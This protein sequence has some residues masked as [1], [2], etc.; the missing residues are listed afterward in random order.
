MKRILKTR[1]GAVAGALLCTLLWGTAFPVIKLSYSRINIQSSDVGSQILFAGQR[2]FLAGVMVFAFCLIFRRKSLKIPR[3][4]IVSVASL[5]L[6]Q[7]AAQYLFSYT[8]LALTTGTKTSVITACSA[9]FAVLLAPVF[10]KNEKL[11]VLKLIGCGVGFLGIVII[12]IS[13]LSG[14]FSLGEA[15]VLIS[16]LCSGFGS[17]LSKVSAGRCDA[18][19]A[20]AYQLLLGGGVLIV[21]GVLMGGSISYQNIQGV[22]LLFYLAFVSAAAFALW[23]VLLGLHSVGRICIFNL[24]IPIFGTVWSGILLGEGVLTVQN[25]ISLALVSGGILIVNLRIGEKK[26]GA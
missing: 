6:V 20:T 26:N 8:G 18:F 15:L 21:V 13:G 25:F 1:L 19:A 7:T 10:F 5:G 17:F 14:G 3:N 24:L 22:L 2:F 16:A 9:F 4:A 12:N 11:T 23:T